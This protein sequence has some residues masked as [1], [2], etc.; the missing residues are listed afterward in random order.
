MFSHVRHVLR[1]LFFVVT[2]AFGFEKRARGMVKAL[3]GWKW[4]R[5]WLETNGM[6]SRGESERARASNGDENK[7]GKDGT[8]KRCEKN[9]RGRDRERKRRGGWL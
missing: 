4:W 6:Q 5:G 3:L 8:A 9:A 1:E 2:A 7:G